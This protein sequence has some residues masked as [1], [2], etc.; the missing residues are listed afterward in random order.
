MV[1]FRGLT[2]SSTRASR[3]LAGS[4]SAST[5]CE[6]VLQAELRRR[7]LLFRANV[8]RL[9]GCPDIVFNHSRVIVFCDG[10]F[11]HG[12]RW[13][14]RRERLKA[15][16][17]SKYWIKK[18]SYN[19]SRDRRLNAE[20]RRQGWAVL[21]VWESAILRNPCRVVDKIASRLGKEAS[22][23]RRELNPPSDIRSRSRRT[24]S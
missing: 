6:R 11:W 20:L 14:D 1:T 2:A 19:M 24:A 10:D 3:A 16:S 12:R 17:N 22:T 9:P 15:G 5:K 18:I 13:R 8:K 21:R 4:R 23:A 7:G